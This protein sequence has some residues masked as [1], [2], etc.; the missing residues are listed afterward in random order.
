MAA[1]VV[2]GFYVKR[3]EATRAWGIEPAS[4]GGVGVSSGGAGSPIAAG[5]YVALSF[6]GVVFYGIV[7]SLD[8]LRTV[9]N[10]DEWSFRLVDN[11]IR[12]RWAI[13]FGQW[14]MP[15]KRSIPH[16]DP[17]PKRTSAI[18]EWWGGSPGFDEPVDFQGL[19]GEGVDA[20]DWNMPL[21][22]KE[23]GSSKRGR[24][25][26]HI[27]PANWSMQSSIYSEG[28]MSA[29]DVL[30]Q[31][32]R[33]S[34]GGGSVGFAFHASQSAPAPAIDANS[35]MSLASL[36]QQLA[37]AQGLQ[38]TMDGSGTIRFERKGGA[39][40]VIPAFADVS[41]VGESISSEPTRV[42]VVG[43]SRLV[44]VNEVPLEPDWN[45]NWE[46]FL[47]EPAWMAEVETLLSDFVEGGVGEDGMTPSMQAECAALARSMTL[48]EYIKAKGGQVEDPSEIEAGF[49]DNGRW[50]NASR[51]DL[52]V[53]VYLNAI[54]FRS[55][56]IP[57]SATLYGLSMRSLRI[58][59][60]LLCAVELKKID[61]ESRTVYRKDPVEY[62]P[63]SAAFVAAKGQPLDLLAAENRDSILRQRKTDVSEAWSEI[64]DFVID[65]ENRSVRFSSPVFIDGA[66]ASGESLLLYPN[67][68]EGDHDDLSADLD[69][70][71]SYLDIVVPNPDCALEPAEVRAA[72]VFEIGVSYYD[73]G[74]G[75]RWTSL[76][77][78]GIA[79]HL[80]HGDADNDLD[81]AAVY[82]G[83]IP[84]P[85]P[86]G[87]GFMEILYEDGSSASAN[88]AAVSGGMIVRS[89]LEQSGT[90]VLRGTAGTSLTSAVDRVTTTLTK[91]EG[92][93]EIV[94]L[95]K[96]RPARGFKS[97]RE[98]A[99]R[100]RTE[101]LFDG[102]AELRKEVDQ[103]H[104]IASLLGAA[105]VTTNEKSRGA[106]HLTLPDML[107]KPLGCSDLQVTTIADP[108]GQYPSGGGAEEGEEGTGWKSG[109]IVWLDGNGVPSRSGSE[110]GGV[111]VAD[112][113]KKHKY[114]AVAKGGKVPVLVEPEVPPGPLFT[115]PGS[116]HASSTGAVH[117]GAL[118]HSESVPEAEADAVPA[119]VNLGFGSALGRFSVYYSPA[120]SRLYV[121]PGSVGFLDYQNPGS[122]VP[123]FPTLEGERLDVPRFFELNNAD[124]GGGGGGGAG[125]SVSPGKSYEVIVRMDGGASYVEMREKASS[126]SD[127]QEEELVVIAVVDFADTDDDS[128]SVD[129]IEQ[130][131]ESDILWPEQPSSSSSER[132]SS[133]ESSSE[134]SSSEESSE[135]SSD[136]EGSEKS[137]NAIVR[138]VAYRTGYCALATVESDEV[139]FEFVIRDVEVR[140][141]HVVLDIDPR[142]IIVCEP[143]SLVVVSAPCGDRPALSV[144]ASVVDGRIH[145]RA[146][147][148]SWLRPRRVN[149]RLTGVRR[150]F[151]GWKMPPRTKE[152]FLANECSL[153]AM[154]PR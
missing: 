82:E 140:S 11:R 108:D 119:K 126:G 36:I 127:P 125:T 39:S 41:R 1:V 60:G 102:Q 79:E 52:P 92:L 51:M 71:S 64:P 58:H 35:G 65:V 109:Q 114:V 8:R 57:E 81:G 46:D 61:D 5:D 136:S 101:P 78:P 103:L 124:G 80:L 13:V 62:Y 25:F 131:W 130:L 40:A 70:N 43:G 19:E 138:M 20:W 14:N 87:E 139:L 105:G 146:S 26:R 53:W 69:E 3:Y 9:Q 137:S 107:R 96:P 154:Y 85:D 73:Y 32:A 99:D 44:Q 34:R 68:G 76:P 24:L 18:D 83:G 30:S 98:I 152:Q 142:Q 145:L 147:K 47:S 28:A 129:G 56:R 104:A 97:S 37:D 63:N 91:D 88:A 93:V 4:G 122:V 144:G 120:E 135:E 45:R 141:S 2:G 77:A 143:G 72:L 100:L 15:E 90:Y 16:S 21:Q 49:S 66:A 150:G 153:K 10:G 113:P 106:S 7:S 74:G 128:V 116:P 86:P 23:S 95:A 17:Y 151:G 54:V 132:S 48:R 148:W 117:I 67:R 6:L 112:V 22:S 38:V 55:Y 31:A 118:D 133:G 149:L 94:E 134:E 12:L 111:V 29:R 42:R 84:A 50:Q 75:A 110:F 123:D 115:S 59:E 33:G 27:P 89:G 121:R